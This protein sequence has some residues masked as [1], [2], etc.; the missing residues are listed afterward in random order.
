M[1]RSAGPGGP[2]PPTKRAAPAAMMHT[3]AAL[4]TRVD[5]A[6]PPKRLHGVEVRLPRTR[7]RA[8]LCLRITALGARG[9][10]A[11]LQLPSARSPR[12]S[13]ARAPTVR[14]RLVM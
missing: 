13:F 9:A 11:A 4:R 10:A 12:T 6:S 8:A 5:P 14:S 1:K 3:P 2:V 7:E